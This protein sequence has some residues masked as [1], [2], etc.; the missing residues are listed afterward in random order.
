MAANLVGR[1]P[2]KNAMMAADPGGSSDHQNLY[3]VLAEAFEQ[4]FQMWKTSTMVTNVMG[5]GPV[6]SFAPPY[7]PVGAVVGGVGTMLPGGFV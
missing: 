6:P 2:L 7:V 1:F 5:T 4:A 3:E